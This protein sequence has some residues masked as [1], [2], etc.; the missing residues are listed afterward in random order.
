MVAF[1]VVAPKDV[2]GAIDFDTIILLL[3]MML[4]SAYLT[5]AGFFRNTAFWVLRLTHTPRMLLIA[6]GAVS[7]LLSAF[8]VN[9]TV[10]LML[11][12]LVLGVAASA[13]LPPAPYLLTLCMASNAGSVATFTGN[14][15]N[16]LIGNLSGQSYAAFAAY[17][18][19]PALVATAVVVATILFTFRAVLPRTRFT[20][21]TVV[22]PV[23]RPLL[24]LCLATLAA[25]VVAFFAGL[26]MAWSALVGAAWVV[27]VSGKPPREQ[28]E[29][30]DWLLLCFFA[31]LFVVVHG[32]GTAG[33]GE[34]I[35]AAFAPLMHGGEGR[36]LVGFSALT[37]V[38]SNVFSNVPFV[39]LARDWV[40]AMTDPGRAW[41]VLALSSTLA[42]NLTLIGS[43]ANL[44]VFEGARGQA[45]VTFWQYFKVGLPATIASMAA[46]LAVLAAEHALF[47]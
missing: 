38:G 16:M 29:K 44:I 1:G 47:G 31:A 27:L 17:M 43:V 18:A 15:Q 20:P 35:R 39:M 30:V 46:A 25:V 23:D 10:C 4:L 12:P 14:P 36:E 2:P 19:L 40:P 26:P 33:Y 7:A 13:D 5:R 6:L 11:T 34:A 32:M 24:I 21:A 22:P 41:Q 37:L 45:E 9:D 28:L 42:G 3:G 8:L